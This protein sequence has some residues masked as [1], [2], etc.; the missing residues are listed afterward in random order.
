MRQVAVAGWLGV[1]DKLE[2]AYVPA[3]DEITE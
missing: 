1:P 3:S 2:E